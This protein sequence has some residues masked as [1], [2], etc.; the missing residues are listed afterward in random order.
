MLSPFRGFRDMQS[1]MERM[2]REA[3]GR[4]ALGAPV[5]RT[6]GAEWAPAVD[7]TTE[8]ENMVIRAELPGLKREDVDL[9]VA[10]GV[11]T[12][13]GER[14]QEE[15]REEGGYL[16]KE[17]RSGSFRRTMT[18]PEGVRTEDI[19]ARF[20]DGVLEVTMPGGAPAVEGGPEKIQIEGPDRG[21][22]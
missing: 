3:F 19:K 7:V 4:T 16:I 2:M 22:E 21:L 8:G 10:N 1:E 14:K 12:V 17:R 13:S 9:T 18:L 11:L 15:E 6:P 5:T 20:E